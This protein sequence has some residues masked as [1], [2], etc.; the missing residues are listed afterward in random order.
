[1]QSDRLGRTKW[2]S[3][4]VCRSTGRRHLLRPALVADMPGIFALPCG[5]AAP[6][7]FVVSGD[8]SVIFEV[9]SPRCEQRL[10]LLERHA[11]LL[12]RTGDVLLRLRQLRGDATP[13]AIAQTGSSKI[14]ELKLPKL[15]REMTFGG[16]S[17]RYLERGAGDPIFYRPGAEN[18]PLMDFAII[19]GDEAWLFQVTVAESHDPKESTLSPFLKHCKQANLHP[20]LVWVGYDDVGVQKPGHVTCGTPPNLTK[21][22]IDIAQYRFSVAVNHREI[23]VQETG[24]AAFCLI[25]RSDAKDD[26]LEAL[27]LMDPSR[28]Y[29]INDLVPSSPSSKASPHKISSSRVAHVKT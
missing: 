9:T 24:S 6:L 15:N 22:V 11:I 8:A 5:S 4:R 1:M 21:Q 13:T 16:N 23:W 25:S 18:F 12:L 20:R 3:W 27:S 14:F 26:V 19:I 17:P 10:R 28:T 7:L 29:T 2:A